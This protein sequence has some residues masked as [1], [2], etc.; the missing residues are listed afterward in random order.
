QVRAPRLLQRLDIEEPNS[1]EML[2]YGVGLELSFSEQI[3][4]VLAN[5]VRS[6]LVGRAVE[7]PRELVN[8]TEVCARCSRS[9]V[10]TLEFLEHQLSKMG[11]NNLLNG[12]YSRSHHHC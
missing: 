6:E 12:G 2:D 9:V 4:L 10:A 7:V 11:H 1:A 5:V 3:R 8:G